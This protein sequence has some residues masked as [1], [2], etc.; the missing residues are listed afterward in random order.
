[1]CVYAEKQKEPANKGKQNQQAKPAAS[2]EPSEDEEEEEA[3]RASEKRTS[4][5]DQATDELMHDYEKSLEQLQKKYNVPG[6]SD[7]L[8]EDWKPYESPFIEMFGDFV[9]FLIQLQ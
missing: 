1:M 5:V 2:Q 3:S 9:R 7:D 4:E 6:D 8:E